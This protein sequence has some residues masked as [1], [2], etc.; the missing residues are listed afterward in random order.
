MSATEYRQRPTATAPRTGG[1]SPVEPGGDG[2]PSLS[3]E[4]AARLFLTR[5][6][7]TKTGSDHTATAY[8]TDLQSLTAFIA[9]RRLTLS[10][11]S[12]AE[13]ARYLAELS[14]E[15]KPRTVRRRIS[16]IRSFY[17]FLRSIEATPDNPFDALDLPS[18]DIKSET[19]KVLTEQ[20]LEQALALLASDA[21][22]ARATFD[23]ARLS[24]DRTRAFRRLFT[25]VRRRA[26]FSLA[27]LGGLRTAEFLGLGVTSFDQTPAGFTVSFQG[28][29]SKRRTVPIVGR[30]YP[31]LVDWL[32]VRRE[33]PTA[34]TTLFIT[35][36]G[37]PVRGNQVRRD[38]KALGERIGLPFPLGPHVLRRTFATHG[39]AATGNLRGVGDLLGH[40]SVSTTQIYTHVD[41]SGLREI[42]EA[43]AARSAGPAPTQ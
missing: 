8:R 4:A 37:K 43:T 38:A 36:Q 7:H 9:R 13:A 27:G 23:A 20:Q 21:A 32:T 18:F 24:V 12:R 35:L 40:A 30:L 2:A 1:V 39:L 22:D 11:V 5:T 16:C 42:A 19:H 3:V 25:A 34:A 41:Q 28:K 31:A 15:V 33:V 10:T 14:A 17:R 6:R 29:G 26:I